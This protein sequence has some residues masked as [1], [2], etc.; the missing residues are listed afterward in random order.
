MV[1][2]EVTLKSTKS[3][4]DGINLFE[5]INKD[6]LNK[7]IT[8]N[9]LLTQSWNNFDNEKNQLLDYKGQATPTCEYNNDVD[10]YMM[11]PIKYKKTNNFTFGRVYPVGSLSLCTIRKEVRQ[12]IGNNIYVDIDAENS[13][14]NLIYQTCKYHAVSCSTLEEYINN[15]QAKLDEVMQVYKVDREKA[16][17]LFIILL[18]FGSFK[19]WL[20]NNSLDINLQPTEYINAFIKERA[21]YGKFI[22]DNNEA[23]YLEVK[24]NK[25]KKNIFVF[26]ETASIVSIWCQEIEN[27]ILECI[28]KYCI[29][30]KYINEKIAVLCYDGLM[31]ETKYYKESILD[32]FNNLIKKNFG[33]DLKFVKKTFD[34]VINLDIPDS[35]LDSDN[36][37]SDDDIENDNDDNSNNND[38]LQQ[39]EN[40]VNDIK[41]FDK[42]FFKGL[43]LVSHK[44]IAGIF[45]TKYTDK[46]VYSPSTGWYAYNK[47]NV[48]INTGK[49]TP[50]NFLVDIT[51]T[52]L[53]YLIP[54][55][56]RMKPNSNSYIKDSK[57]LNRL[58]KEVSNANFLKGVV[59]FLKDLFT[60]KDIDEKIDNNANLLAFTNKLFDKSTYTIRD[61][62]PDDFICKT[63]KYEYLESNKKI[64]KD[65]QNIIHSI[66][67]DKE[68]EDYFINIKAKSLFGNKTEKFIIQ[69][70]SGGNGKSLTG[71][72]ENTGLGDYISTTE[73]TFLTSAFKQGSANPT[74]AKSKGIRN[75][76]I[77]EPSEENELGNA[78]ALNTPF[79]KLISGNDKIETRQLYGTN[80]SFKPLFTAFL[81][82]NT[83]PNIKKVDRGIMRR[84]E[85][86]NY[87]LSFVENPIEPNERKINIT[88][89][90]KLETIEYGREYIL[91]LLDTITKIKDN[92]IKTPQS[93]KDSSNNYFTEN[94]PVKNYIDAF[95]LK[96]SGCKVKSTELK[97]H[98]DSHSEMKIN[99]RDFIKH[100]TANGITNYM[101]MGYRFFKD[102]EI[103]EREQIDM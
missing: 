2:F 97:E 59:A 101:S 44:Q 25:T 33:Y 99:I 11:I 12:T 9:K 34:K 38:N 41:K 61:I 10:N 96:K 84:I 51:T 17:Q 31:I 1:A 79:L 82:C 71:S 26:N 100:M 35:G 78:T 80:F 32:A 52:L 14:P 87:P 46:Y 77:P 66:F 24:A 85:V 90:D 83:L 37:D 63:T 76:I 21:I 15:R 22:E 93:I 4:L 81:Q 88:L 13:H 95:L 19:T 94:N 68:I 57:N 6:K 54:I 43:E 5:I 64:R 18:Y 92:D 53:N 16:K 23:I 36:I 102:I 49:E 45:H 75:L 91:L 8:S 42:E 7:L 29:K 69:T 86:I 70:G 56:N 62:R 40:N 89:K 74:L 58:L 67:E 30:N 39:P 47:Y 27:R 3:A 65:I 50:I 20:R 72:L 28:Y 55:R 73:N 103:D 98:Y 48:L 60:N